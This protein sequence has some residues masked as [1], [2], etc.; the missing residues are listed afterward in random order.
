MRF[1]L[2]GAIAHIIHNTLFFIRYFNRQFNF[3]QD[4][5]IFKLERY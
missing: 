5:N 4:G 2:N 1:D 3:L